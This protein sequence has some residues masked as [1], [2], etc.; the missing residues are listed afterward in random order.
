MG[1]PT[2]D[3]FVLHCSLPVCRAAEDGA[4]NYNVGRRPFLEP[5]SRDEI[6]Q[7]LRA[8]G[9]GDVAALN[10]LTPVVYD[11]LKRIAIGYMRRERPGNSL[12][13]TALVHE[14]YLKL[15]DASFAEWQDRAHFF[16]VA[17]RLMRRILVDAARSR[18]A[19]KRGGGAMRV[20]IN[21]SNDGV[22]LEN[23]QMTRLDDALN[24]LAS[25]D[26]RKADVVELRFFGGLSV[27]ETAEVLKISS[28]SVMRDWKLARSWLAREMERP[29]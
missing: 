18:E 17:A 12:Q 15:V 29:G 14:A 13:P 10:R 16:A 28:Q 9:S 6:T 11:E 4:E 22:A 5:V 21:E 20:E 23:R 19:G 1:L 25:F 26:A 7:A 3:A 2:R 8:W 27:E 24:A